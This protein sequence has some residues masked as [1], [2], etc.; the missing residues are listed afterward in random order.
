MH[1]LLT[2]RYICNITMLDHP[3]LMEKLTRC[4]WRTFGG[5]DGCANTTLVAGESRKLRTLRASRHTMFVWP[6]ENC[7]FMV[8]DKNAS[9]SSVGRRVMAAS[10]GSP[11]LSIYLLFLH[12]VLS[13]CRLDWVSCRFFIGEYS[14]QSFAIFIKMGT[15]TSILG[16]LLLTP[17][18]F[19]FA[20]LKKW[21]GLRAM[22]YRM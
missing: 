19:C 8:A 20:F 13:S 2:D 11:S 16:V 22:Q 14:V 6:N 3:I 12:T 1:L 15:L 10:W 9:V 4:L 18:L 21:Y 7:W 17:I 5:I